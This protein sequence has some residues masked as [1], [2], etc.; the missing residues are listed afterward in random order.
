MKPNDLPLVCLPLGLCDDDAATLL[1]FLY[2]LTEALE[3]HYGGE[4]RRR[5]HQ[6]RICRDDRS[7]AQP[8]PTDPSF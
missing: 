5:N 1:Q 6:Q 3:S 4:L 7:F 2:D 8:D